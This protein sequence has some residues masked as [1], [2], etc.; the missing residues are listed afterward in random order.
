MRYLFYL[1]LIGLALVVQVTL[2]DLFA[3]RGVKPDLCIIALCYIS[4]R[5][6]RRRAVVWGFSAG[7]VEDLLNHALLGPGALARSVAS[8]AAGTFLSEHAFHHSYQASFRVMGIALLN[9]VVL[10]AVLSLIENWSSGVLWWRI[11]F[12]TLY[13]EL[14]TLI[15]FSLISQ[16]TWEKLYK[17]DSDPFV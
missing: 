9:N 14:V 6:G 4:M 13:T 7:L 2:G 10:F 17:A 12:S 5:E 15:L 1:F 8:F 16:E 3:V 11:L